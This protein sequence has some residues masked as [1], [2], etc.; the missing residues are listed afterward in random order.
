MKWLN[1]LLPNK[2]FWIFKKIR[3]PKI[4]FKKKL[5]SLDQLCKIQSHQSK[6]FRN[7]G[8]KKKKPENKV[9]IKVY[10]KKANLGQCKSNQDKCEGG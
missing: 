7:S 5:F 2:I 6:K 8:K 10:V 1:I 4:Y 3:L 9:K